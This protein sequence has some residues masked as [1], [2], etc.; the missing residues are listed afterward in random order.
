[1]KVTMHSPYE[2]RVY[3]PS[4]LLLYTY[5]FL[6][7]DLSMT[8]FKKL[9]GSKIKLPSTFSFLF[10]IPVSLDTQSLQTISLG[11]TSSN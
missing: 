10:P 7:N 5:P 9:E 6:S 8:K 2:I 1:M 11:F 3:C 4:W